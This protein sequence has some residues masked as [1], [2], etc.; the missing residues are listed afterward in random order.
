[1]KGWGSLV[2]RRRGGAP[3]WAGGGV[4]L[5]GGQVEGWGSLVGRWRGGAPW[6]AGG[7][8]VVVGMFL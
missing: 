4:G 6:W 7:G 3:W 8:A 2:G 5:P 1:M